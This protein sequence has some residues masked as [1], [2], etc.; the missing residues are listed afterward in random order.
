MK[1]PAVRGV[2]D[3]RILVNYRVD[4][5]ALDRVLPEPFDPKPVDGHAVGGI[6][7]IRLTGVR[8]PG[9]PAAFGLDSENAA[10]RIAVEWD[11]SSDGSGDGPEVDGGRRSGVYVPRRDTSSRLNAVLG[12]R[13]FSSVQHHA[14]FETGESGDRYRVRME[15]DD[16]EVT[17]AV[18]GT[19]TD[20]LPADSVFD[21]VSASSSFFR[22]GSLG[23]SPRRNGDY[24]GVELHTHEWAVTPLA[25]D[26]VTSSFF[27]G[28]RFPDDAVAFDHALLM[29]DIDH[30]W[31]QREPLCAP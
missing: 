13:L 26:S 7:L 9:V 21:S 4:P 24:D 27:E 22:D 18:D 5:A 6:C 20:A 19:V 23:Y 3:R 12:G 31:R 30:E 16:D 28:E 15:S 11:G 17:V 2:I 29:R 25:V 8:P 1:L 14:R 10:H